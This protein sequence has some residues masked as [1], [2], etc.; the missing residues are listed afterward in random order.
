MIIF[1]KQK[2]GSKQNLLIQ[3]YE[4]CIIDLIQ[5]KD[6]QSTR[7][8]IQH[9]DVN[10][11]DHC[12][13]VSYRSYL[14]CIRLGLDYKSAARGGLLHD[15]FLYDWHLTKPKKGLHGF[16][17]PKTALEN[18]DKRFRLNAKEKDI[19]LK[20][21]WPLTISL[22]RYKETVVVLMVDN[23]CTMQ[24]IIEYRFA[25]LNKKNRFRL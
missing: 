2:F 16:T 14:I 25:Q 19:I 1:K 11:L 8:Y 22:P 10:C 5:N 23:Y 13:N 6:V 4:E 12:I 20:H 9:G 18:A 21:M 7:N 3:T 17:H 15:F 24:E